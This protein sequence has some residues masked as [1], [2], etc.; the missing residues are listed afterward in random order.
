[1]PDVLGLEQQVGRSREPQPD[2]G[3]AGRAA[4]IE[5]SEPVAMEGCEVPDQR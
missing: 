1:V 3:A 2:D 5:E 4:R